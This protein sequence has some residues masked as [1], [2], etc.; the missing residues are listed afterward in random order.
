MKDCSGKPTATRHE[1]RGPGTE[2]PTRRLAGHVQKITSL[3]D[4]IWKRSAKVQVV[5]STD[6][7]GNRLIHF[8]DQLLKKFVANHG[9]HIVDIPDGVVF[10][11]VGTYNIYL[12]VLDDADELAGS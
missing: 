8:I 7:S 12:D 5:F 6:Q 11:Q 1:W 10:Y 3:V 4:K 9:R 2:S